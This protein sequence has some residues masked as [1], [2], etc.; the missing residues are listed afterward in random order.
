M[1][2]E[3]ASL[4]QVPFLWV[5]TLEGTGT[6]LKVDIFPRGAPFGEDKDAPLFQ[7]TVTHPEPGVLCWI[8]EVAR[9]LRTQK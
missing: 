5:G 8:A 2:E 6:V 3:T 9:E 7:G 4:E 1:K